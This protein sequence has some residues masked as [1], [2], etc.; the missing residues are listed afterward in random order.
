M[1][2]QGAALLRAAVIECLHMP[3]ILD[4]RVFVAIRS[5]PH[6]TPM[7]VL[8]ETLGKLATSG[9]IWAIGV[10][11]ARIRGIERSGR[12]LALLAPTLGLTGFVA[13]KPAKAYFARRRSFRHLVAMMV[14]GVKPRVPSFPSGHAATSFASALSLGAVWP[15]RRPVFVLLASIVSF[16]RVYLG[17]H[18]PDEILAGG[19][20]GVI[21]AELLRSPMQ[22]LVQRVNRSH[23]RAGGAAWVRLLLPRP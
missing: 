2:Q 16:S 14:L 7:L 12:A 20:L 9:G 17:L 8:C 19:A 11:L 18:G 22:R 6:P 4:A 21:L 13:E 3:E 23:R 5:L 15:Y 10:G 1:T